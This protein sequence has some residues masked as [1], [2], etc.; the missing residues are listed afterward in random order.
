M[1]SSCKTAGVTDRIPGILPLQPGLL[2]WIAP[3]R[4]EDEVTLSLCPAPLAMK[5]E[6]PYDKI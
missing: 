5:W 3:L 1:I 4:P 2:T 6:V